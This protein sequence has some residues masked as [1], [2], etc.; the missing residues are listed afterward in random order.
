MPYPDDYHSVGAPDR[1]SDHEEREREAIVRECGAAGR[2]LD[3]VLHWMVKQFDLTDQDWADLFD[4][5]PHDIRALTSD[6]EVVLRAH[7]FT[8]RET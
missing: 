1:G 4:C 6:L 2:E 5:K 3:D 7:G 8:R